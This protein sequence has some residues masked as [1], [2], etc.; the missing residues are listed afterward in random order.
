MWKRFLEAL[1]KEGVK[2]SLVGSTRADDIVR[3]A[4]HLH[5]YKQAGVERFLMGTENTDEDVLEKIK[6][7]G[8]HDTDREAVRLMRKHN[9]LSMVTWVVGFEEERNRD[10]WRQ[11]QKPPC[12]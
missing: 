6:K 5:L 12:L 8:S 10:C 7:G 3:D 9:M 4:A 2:V 1:A 11:F